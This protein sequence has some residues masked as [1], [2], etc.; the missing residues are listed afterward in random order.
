MGLG[1]GATHDAIREF[2]VQ[3]G[4][5][6][7]GFGSPPDP[8]AE[9]PAGE[10][11]GKFLRALRADFSYVV[12]DASV[13]YSDSALVCFDLSD[14]ICLVTAA[15]RGRCQAPLQGA[16]HAAHDRAAA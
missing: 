5:H 1:E 9:P 13:D 12:V 4:E 10:A 14:A 16:R 2:G 15:R 7:W 8:A 3:L 11:V 6:L